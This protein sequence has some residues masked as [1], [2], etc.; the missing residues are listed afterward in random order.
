MSKSKA[1]VLR[2]IWERLIF[3]DGKMVLDKI[4]RKV[5]AGRNCGCTGLTTPAAA[6]AGRSVTTFC[7]RV[8]CAVRG[9]NDALQ[10]QS[11]HLVCF[12]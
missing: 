7:G 5:S 8:D 2:K 3:L 9:W 12:C 11:L 10:S 4:E 6:H 1:V